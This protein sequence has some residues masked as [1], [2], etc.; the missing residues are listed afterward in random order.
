VRSRE[1]AEPHPEPSPSQGEVPM[2]SP[3]APLA[4]SEA[5]PHP[6]LA[7]PSLAQPGKALADKP[8]C[9]LASLGPATSQMEEEEEERGREEKKRKEKN[10]N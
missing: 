9:V 2:S 4:T 7:K 5:Q 3:R 6:A 1:L 10:M 8:H